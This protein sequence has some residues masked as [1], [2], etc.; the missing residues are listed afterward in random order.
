MKSAFIMNI[1]E[2]SKL[3]SRK[4]LGH[5]PKLY[6]INWINDFKYTQYK[7]FTVASILKEWVKIM[8]AFV[9]ECI[10]IL[11]PGA[12]EGGEAIGDRPP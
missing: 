8:I 6:L 5:C 1:Q 10:N 7:D 11:A 12:Q 2:N 3:F 4:V 9:S